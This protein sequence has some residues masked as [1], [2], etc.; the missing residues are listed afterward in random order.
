MNDHSLRPGCPALDF[1]MW[2]AYACE[3]EGVNQ[4]LAKQNYNLELM[5]WIAKRK[6]CSSCSVPRQPGGRRMIE[7]RPRS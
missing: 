3:L 5:L 2:F 4:R 1:D 7:S 6:T